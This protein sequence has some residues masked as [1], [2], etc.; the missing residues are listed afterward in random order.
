M[1]YIVKHSKRFRKFYL[2]VGGRECFLKYETIGEG[3][4][5]FKVLFVPKD[6][7]NIGIAERVLKRAIGYSEKNNFKIRSGCSYIN[8]FIDAHPELKDIISKS[9]EM[10]TWVLHYN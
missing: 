3:V 9:P 10:I 4:L 1:S 5:D 8:I 6:L 7:R 2:N